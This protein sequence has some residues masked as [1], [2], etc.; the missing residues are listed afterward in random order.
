MAWATLQKP[1]LVFADHL[2]CGPGV[3]AVCEEPYERD[4]HGRPSLSSAAILHRV[5]YV[6]S[7]PD[8]PACLAPVLASAESLEQQATKSA[9]TIGL[10]LQQ[11]SLNVLFGDSI[12]GNCQNVSDT[13]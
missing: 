4:L 7:L 1:E 9:L 5:H 2:S 13:S 11:L 10:H 6:S 3:H 8:L 12:N